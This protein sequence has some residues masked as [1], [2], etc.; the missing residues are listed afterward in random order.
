[1]FMKNYLVLLI[2]A[3]SIIAC[4]KDDDN[5][6]NSN[7]STVEFNQVYLSN[8]GRTPC[9]GCGDITYNFE[10]AFLGAG[11]TV[12]DGWRE[13]EN[14]GPMMRLKFY[15]ETEGTP[16]SGV[17]EYLSNNIVPYN[18]HYAYYQTTENKY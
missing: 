12:V 10:L 13:P 3:I 8:L 16:K 7:P 14:G 5:Q 17:Y 2:L 15:S 6:L 11:V 4:E 1:M 9:F 18:F